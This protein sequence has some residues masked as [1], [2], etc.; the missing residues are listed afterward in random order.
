MKATDA[1]LDPGL[2]SDADALRALAAEYGL[3]CLAAVPDAA[4]DPELVRDLPV[5]WARANVM[6][7][8]RMP[9]GLCVAVAGP[10]GIARL[11]DVALVF[12][13]EWRPVLAPRE[14][15]LEAIERC[16]FRRRDTPGDFL[17]DM[18]AGPTAERET[19]T[20]DLLRV[21]R[22]TP[23]TQLVNLVLLEAVKQGASDIHVE[24][25]ES[26]LRVRYR[27]D[28]VLY[29]Q[30][31]PPKRVEEALVS[32]LKVMGRLDIAERRLPQ[33]GMA[34]VSVGER[35][36]DI[37]V[38]TVPV[39]EGERVVLRLLDQ[40]T[41]LLPLPSLGMPPSV[42][43]GMNRLMADSHG[44]IVVC[45]P[46]GSGKTT[47]LYAA[48]ANL[49][50]SRKNILTIEDPIEYQL[51]EI[52][53]IQV[54]PKIGLTFATGLR[55][56]LRQDPDIILVG[57]TRDLET[58]EIAVRAALTGHLVF[59]T[60]HTN[61]AAGAVIR[62]LDMGIEPYL[63]ATCLRGVLAQRLV[64]RLCP[65]CRRSHTPGPAEL[66]DLGALAPRVAGHPLFEPVGCAQCLEGFRGRTGIFE[67]LTLNAAMQRMVRSGASAS[68]EVR[69][70]AVGQGCRTLA[71]DAIAK[72]L[73]G[74]TSLSE[75][76]GTV[77]P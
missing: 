77:L 8:L 24:P 30:A 32:R 65:S 76:I 63:L 48:L 50:A 42:L 36:I 69:A 4:I 9:D 6:L 43:D 49:D 17:K 46:T 20:D 39:A 27:I 3:T 7:P 75:V 1:P 41:A 12:P 11:D 56:I 73:D 38:S 37:R 66:R 55:H 62:L 34:R 40:R 22:T 67:L 47:T 14:A 33:D 21:A 29:E 53:Q 31:S 64:R 71:E 54:K 52:G 19:T 68:D 60:L 23:V 26:R 61:D 16:Y 45:G 58:A 57:E 44:M 59:T 10:A 35:E 13:G 25:Y 51:P 70:Y 15:I 5:E 28:G 18:G 2:P 74:T 72:A